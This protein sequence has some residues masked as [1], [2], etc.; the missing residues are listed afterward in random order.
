MIK[1]CHSFEPEPTKR[2]DFFSFPRTGSHYL[3]TS[4]AALFDLIQYPQEFAADP[5]VKQRAEEISPYTN[6]VLSLRENGAPYKPVYIDTSPNGV[7]GTPKAGK[8]PI[9]LLVRDP[10]ATVFSWYFTSKDRW[11]LFEANRVDW[12]RDAYRQYREFYQLGFEIVKAESPSVFLVRYEDL[13]RDYST[14]ARLARFIGVQPKLNPEFVFWWT[15]FGRMTKPGP[16]TFYRAGN[17]TKWKE[18]PAWLADLQSA[19]IG[20]F[21]EF[22]YPDKP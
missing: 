16:R 13:K 6:Y 22:G 7:H 5:E 14:L 9:I 1:D 10:H 18:D 12:I 17:N 4:L 11:H 19:E 3:G 20:S 15:G 2:L 8:W 21:G